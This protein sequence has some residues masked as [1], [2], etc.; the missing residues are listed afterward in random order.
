MWAT[1][2]WSAVAALATHLTPSTRAG[3]VVSQAGRGA[4]DCQAVHRHATGPRHGDARHIVSRGSRWGARCVS[5][6]PQRVVRRCPLLTRRRPRG[7]PSTCPRTPRATRWRVGRVAWMVGSGVWRRE[8]TRFPAAR[9]AARPCGG[10]PAV[11]RRSTTPPASGPRWREWTSRAPRAAN[12]PR[13][14]RAVGSGTNACARVV[15]GSKTTVGGG[16]PRSSS[17]VGRATAA[18]V[19]T[20][21]RP[22]H[23][24]R[25]PA[26]RAQALPACLTRW[27]N[28]ANAWPLAP[29]SPCSVLARRSRAVM[30]RAKAAPWG[31]ATW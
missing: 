30:V 1:H 28:A 12:S 22:G 3:W 18:G 20:V 7:C 16:A 5:T 8:R 17:V 9:N 31:C 23:T 15:S 10:L 27:R 13:S 19:T 25:T 26:G 24:A 14:R 4:E 11:A 2:R 6:E 21:Q 29:P